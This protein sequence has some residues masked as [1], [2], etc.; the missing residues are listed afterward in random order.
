MIPVI[1]LVVVMVKQIINW[2]KISKIQ[3]TNTAHIRTTSQNA[4][5]IPNISL[6]TS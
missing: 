1:G 2:M 4:I 5:I 3:F 6:K